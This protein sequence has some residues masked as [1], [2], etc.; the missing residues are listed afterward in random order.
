MSCRTLSTTLY[1]ISQYIVVAAICTGS[2]GNTPQHRPPPPPLLPGRGGGPSAMAMNI[3]NAKKIIKAPATQT[4]PMRSPL[5]GLVRCRKDRAGGH[6]GG[7]PVGFPHWE[8]N[9]A[10]FGKSMAQ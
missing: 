9:A 3:M 4:H 1:D 8:Q 6:T 2:G 7:F 10:S 5:P